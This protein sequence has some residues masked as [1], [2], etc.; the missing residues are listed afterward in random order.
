MITDIDILEA[1]E[2]TLPQI[3]GEVLGETPCLH[4]VEKGF[5]KKCGFDDRNPHNG[6]DANCPIANPIPLTWDNAMKHFRAA[7]G[8]ID[9][10]MVSVFLRAVDDGQ[11]LA[12]R[13]ASKGKGPLSENAIAWFLHYAQPSHYLKVACLCKLNAK[14]KE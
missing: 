8:D 3:A 5:C 7:D 9:E 14:E 2:D 10:A 6:Y 1:T 12:D 13:L 11:G 4:K